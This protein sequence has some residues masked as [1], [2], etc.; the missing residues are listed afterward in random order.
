MKRLTDKLLTEADGTGRSL[1]PVQTAALT[2]VLDNW[3]TGLP[4]V[5]QMPTGAGKSLC[6]VSIAK[7]LGN[8][9]AL[10]APSNA[11]VEQYRKDY[12]DI[13]FWIGKKHYR[14]GKQV[15]GKKKPKLC[16][17]RKPEECEH[18]CAYR[19]GLHAI[20]TGQLCIFNPMSY[21]HACK[22]D[23]VRAYPYLLIDE[24]HAVI[25][26]LHFHNHY[27]FVFEDRHQSINY[28]TLKHPK[29]LIEFLRK[30]AEILRDEYVRFQHTYKEGDCEDKRRK[31]QRCEFIAQNIATA[32]ENFAITATREKV[33]ITCVKITP[34]LVKRIFGEPQRLILA[35]GTMFQTDID[36]YLHGR[37]HHY[38]D[39]PSPIPIKNRQV[40][41]EA[42]PFKIN[43]LTAAKDIA[44]LIESYIAMH[45]STNILVHLTYSLAK[46][47][48]P[49]MRTPVITHTD[50]TKKAMLEYWE[51]H[52]GVFF[53][54][55]C[56][57]GL[58]LKDDKCRVN[59]IV[60]IPYANL[61]NN[62]VQKQKGQQ[63]GDKRFDEHA[64]K[65]VIQAA[66]RSTRSETDFST[67]YILDPSFSALYKRIEAIPAYFAESIV[68]R[69]SRHV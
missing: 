50:K 19:R 39:L 8:G 10:I 35:S 58:D 67:T 44:D 32:E 2:Y 20:Q 48:A 61:A 36:D 14:C 56:T 4:F 42:A 27:D 15:E 22:R 49:F 59:I 28:M 43:H 41:F 30:E 57:E 54:S 65:H 63:S 34:E 18:N 60:K 6:L 45:P 47:V 7:Q 64:M 33:S 12:P 24:A 11:L 16:Y 21:Y 37:R 68:W 52:G 26:A 9:A 53:G 55:G 69:P 31:I 23:D 66:G 29:T 51:E 17:L 46:K 13:P 3:Q 1:R 5:L 25:S 38:L 62:V 40:F